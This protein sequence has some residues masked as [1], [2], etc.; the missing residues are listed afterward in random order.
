[1]ENWLEGNEA[2]T[3]KLR[4]IEA[5]W[6]LSGNIEPEQ[7]DLP[8]EMRTKFESIGIPKRINNFRQNNKWFYALA[9]M[10]TAAILSFGIYFFQQRNQQPHPLVWKSFST[11]PGKIISITLPD[12]S[13]VLLNSGSSLFYSYPEKD[14]GK[15]LVRLAGEAF[16]EVTHDPKRPFVVESDSLKTT[17]YGTSFNVRA[18]KNEGNIAVAVSSGKVGVQTHTT[19]AVFLLPNQ[20]AVYNKAKAQMLSVKI[21]SKDIH[22]WDQGILI[23]EQTPIKEVFSALS[24]RFDIPFSTSAMVSE[25]CKLTARFENQSLTQILKTLR[26]AMNIKSDQIN[27][28]IYVEGGQACKD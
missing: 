12:R 20:Q 23:F 25:N 1:L 22:A 6:L 11:A 16:F 17:V 15:R 18:Y 4:N 3:E 13:K 2:N 24:R 5:L 27:G 9:A 28:T 14:E 26:T 10:L 19:N 21:A 7:I 8:S